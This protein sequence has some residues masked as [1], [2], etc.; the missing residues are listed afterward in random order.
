M[1]RK[2]KR[3]SRESSGSESDIVNKGKKIITRGPS[4]DTNVSVSDILRGA[5]DVLYETDCVTSLE[6][7]GI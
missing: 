3:K 4:G 2:S 5:N 7:V 6:I 1:G